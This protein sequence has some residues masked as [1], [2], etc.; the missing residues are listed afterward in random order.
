MRA[1]DLFL[2]VVFASSVAH[3]GV[4]E[5]YVSLSVTRDTAPN[6]LE[7]WI[8]N[9][10]VPCDFFQVAIYGAS[11]GD[12]SLGSACD[13]AHWSVET[14]TVNGYA[15]F[16]AACDNSAFYVTGG[17]IVNVDGCGWE[18]VID[19]LQGLPYTSLHGSGGGDTWDVSEYPYLVSSVGGSCQQKADSESD[20]WSLVK[21]FYR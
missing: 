1:R 5:Q 19:T 20:T 9:T 14:N 3:A 12:L 4:V 15:I 16:Q 2:A 7:L 21:R 17:E 18:P 11:V 13:P 10:S 8:D 6:S